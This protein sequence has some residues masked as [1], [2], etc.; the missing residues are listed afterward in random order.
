VGYHKVVDVYQDT[1]FRTLAFVARS[2]AAPE[3]FS[4]LSGT[5]LDVRSKPIFNRRVDLDL[6]N[7]ERHTTFTHSRG[8]NRLVLPAQV[9]G[10]VRVDDIVKTIA[11]TAG[12]IDLA[13]R[14]GTE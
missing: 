7:G 9:A 10:Q 2:D 6:P 12:S 4:A 1:M 8:M 13:F 5:V 3:T 11:L 14:P